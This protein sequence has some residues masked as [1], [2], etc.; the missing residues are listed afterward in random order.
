MESNGDGVNEKIKGDGQFKTLMKIQ[1]KELTMT[2]CVINKVTSTENSQKNK[3]QNPKN[4]SE[5][6]QIEKKL[7]IGLWN[8]GG[9]FEEGKLKHLIGEVEMFLFDIVVLQEI[10]NWLNK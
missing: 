9:T 1:G 3:N 4:K 8:V 2:N 7:L 6:N 5:I 10:N